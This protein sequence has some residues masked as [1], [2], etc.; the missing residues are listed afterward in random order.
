MRETE[1]IIDHTYT[2]TLPKKFPE[3]WGL[4]GFQVGEHVNVPSE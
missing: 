1:L 2:M 4:E 3:L